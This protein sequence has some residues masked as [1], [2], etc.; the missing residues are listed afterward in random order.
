MEERLGI[1]AVSTGD[2]LEKLN[3]FIEGAPMRST[4]TEAEQKKVSHK[5]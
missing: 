3:L 5:H 2:L 1:I 4:C